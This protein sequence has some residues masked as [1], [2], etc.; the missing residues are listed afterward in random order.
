[1]TDY[2]VPTDEA[3]ALPWSWAGERLTRSK[4]YWVVT[5]SASGRPHALPVWGVWLADRDLFAFSCSPNARK[6]RNISANPRVVVCADDTVEVVSVEGT[7]RP[8][9][10]DELDAAVGAYVVK[11]EPDETKR[12]ALESFMRAHAA[13]VVEPERAFGI[14][15]REDEFATR[16]TRWVWT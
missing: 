8:P 9:T 10:S 3:G 4:N 5:A 1:M 12:A 15:E 7:A 16:A 13:F 2:G 14:I 11:Y 6:A